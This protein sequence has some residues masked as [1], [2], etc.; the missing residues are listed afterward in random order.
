MLLRKEIFMLFS[1][2]NGSLP[3]RRLPTGAYAA[4]TV[5]LWHGEGVNV[6]LQAID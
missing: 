5:Q 2:H 4:E 6:M 1:D 3:L